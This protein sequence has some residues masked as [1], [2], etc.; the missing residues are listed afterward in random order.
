MERRQALNSL[1]QCDNLLMRQVKQ[2]FVS[3]DRD[4]CL[5]IRPHPHLLPPSVQ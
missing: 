3:F 4:I 1:G 2:I 5:T